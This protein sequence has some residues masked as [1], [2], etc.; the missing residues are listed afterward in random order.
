M[1]ELLLEGLALADV[2]R[3]Q[4]DPAHVLVVEQV[5]VQDLELPVAAVAVAQR[6]LDDLAVAPRIGGAVGEHAQQPLGVVAAPRGGRS[7][8]RRARAPGSRARARRRG[9]GRR[10]W[11]PSPTTVIRSLERC[12]SEAKRASLRCRWIFSLRRAPS[13]ARA[14]CVPSAF[15]ASRSCRVGAAGSASS[16]SCGAPPRTGSASTA[17]WRSSPGRSSAV[18][19]A[20]SSVVSCAT[21][22]AGDLEQRPAHVGGERARGPLGVVAEPR[23]GEDAVLGDAEERRAATLEQARGDLERHVLHLLARGA[24]HERG[25]ERAQQPLALDRALLLAYE[26]GHPHHDE[27]RT[28]PSRRRRSRSGRRRCGGA[29][30]AGCR[31]ARSAMRR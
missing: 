18:S 25:A 29:P 5:R 17:P 31:S 15:S 24:G 19:S 14:S 9:S 10:S 16:S 22:G 13:S 20:G 8:C 6:A 23:R 28:A 3:V 30:S 1:R 26:I 12:T 21:P 4:H 11:R 7:A 2:A 27:R